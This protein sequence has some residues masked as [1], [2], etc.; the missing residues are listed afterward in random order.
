MMILENDMTTK[1]GK[2]NSKSI[3]NAAAA[4]S[5]RS[6]VITAKQAAQRL[7][8]SRSTIYRVDRVRGPFQFIIDGRRIFIDLTSFASHLADIRGIRADD[9]PLR[10]ESMVQYQHPANEPKAE[11]QTDE[12]QIE[13]SKTAI[14]GAS[15]PASDGG[16]QRD[17]IMREPTGPCVVCYPSFMG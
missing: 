15:L 11:P 2:I 17:L 13:S 6:T 5:T 3:L 9:D 14:S 12:L 4:Q 1:L 16:G 10:V 8:V 7:G